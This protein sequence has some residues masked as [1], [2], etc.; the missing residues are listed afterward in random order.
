LTFGHLARNVGQMATPGRSST[1][2]PP[3]REAADV[4]RFVDF[5]HSGK[6][7]ALSYVLLLGLEEFDPARLLE[8]VERGLGFDSL[9]RL[10]RNLDLP[11]ARVLDIVQI[12]Q[13]TMTRRRKEGRFTADESDRVLRAGRVFGRA[14]E[15]FGGDVAAARR[16]LSAP[17]AVLG[18]AVPWDLART[19]VGARE[20][21]A[22]VGR[23]EHGVY[24]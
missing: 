21:E 3:I 20:V 11:F 13:R 4:G 12:P 1:L 2:P 19:E 7:G 23:I 22:A 24:S 9:L 10:Q 6:P 14:I 5:V 17:Q 8:T 15:L 18:G 16:W